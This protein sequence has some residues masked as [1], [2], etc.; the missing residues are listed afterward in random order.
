MSA[1]IPAEVFPPGEFIKDELEARGWTQVDLAEVLGRPAKLVSELLAAKRQITPQT[2]TGLAEAFGTEPQFWMNLESAYQLSKTNQQDNLVARRSRL[3]AKVPVKE[4]VRRGWIEST[5][6]VDVLES[7][8]LKFLEIKSIDEEPAS[9]AYAAKATPGERPLAQV[10]WQLRCKQIAR[11]QLVTKYSE[12]RLRSAVDHFR[13]LLIDPADIGSVARVLQEC[14]VRLV[15]VEAL[16]GSKI[17]GACFWLDD[18]SPV[19]ALS[20]LHDRIDNFWFVL[21]HEIEHVLRRDGAVVDTDLGSNDPNASEQERIA[22][23]AA[24]DFCVPKEKLDNWI[25]R[26]GR[27]LSEADL[28]GFASVNRVH[29]G[30]VAGQLCKRTGNHKR[31]SKHRVKVR[32]VLIATAPV[33][34][35]GEIYPAD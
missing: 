33:D 24:G 3:Y 4:L 16:P 9:V 20:N 30:I 13:K 29:P 32:Q 1:R 11:R 31:F 35:W 10:L 5:D 22:N 23:S 15:V 25:L 17:D 34:G 27:F 26:K 7:R 18:D 19:V 12:G 28:L 2:A 6:S 14:G 8:V 21:R